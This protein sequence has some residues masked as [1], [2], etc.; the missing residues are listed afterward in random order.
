VSLTARHETLQL[1]GLEIHLRR[2][3]PQPQPERP[4]LYCLHGWMDNGDTFQ[5]LADALPGDR[6]LVA[7]DWRGFGR[8]AWAQGEYA[9]TDY[10]ADLDALLQLFSPNDPAMLLGHSM[11]GNVAC[12]YAGLRP[13]RV[14]CVVTLEGFGMAPTQPSQAPQRLRQWLEE[15]RTTPSFNEYG[16]FE[17]L[18]DSIRRRHPRIDAARALELA[19]IW[20]REEEP[21]RVR[22][23]G[24]PRH[25]RVF[26]QL[27]HREESAAIWREIRAPLLAVAGAES[28]YV[29]Q[30]GAGSGIEDFLSCVPGSTLRTIDGAGHLLHLEKPEIIAPLIGEFLDSH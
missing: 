12:I 17:Q 23:W 24:D 11:G 30:L 1:R 29:S 13:G 9:F 26:P 16:S 20:A 27:Y 10:V 6:A 14:R 25:K 3:G 19:R 2:W 21:G 7:A 8:S 15:L 28:A 5:F 22:L 4:P 18:A